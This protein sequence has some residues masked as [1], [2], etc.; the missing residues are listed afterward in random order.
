M[1]MSFSSDHHLLWLLLRKDDFS[2]LVLGAVERHA[3]KG[4]R[5]NLFQADQ[6]NIRTPALLALGEQFIVNLTSTEDQCLHIVRIF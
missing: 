1:Y 4:K 6:C 5:S 2:I 3:I